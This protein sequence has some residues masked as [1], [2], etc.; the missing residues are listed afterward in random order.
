MGGRFGS[1][2]WDLRSTVV[3]GLA[4]LTIVSVLVPSGVSAE[5]K[6]RCAK[7]AHPGGDWSTFG[8]DAANSRYQ[9]KEKKLTADAVGLIAPQWTFSIAG[10]GADGNFQSSPVVADGCLYAG[11]NTGWLFGL[12][13]DTGE[14]VWKTHLEADDPY[15]FGL[16]GGVFS[17]AH[18]D[19]KI[20]GAVSALGSPY[21]VALDAAT[22]KIL[23]KTVVA[24]DKTAYTNASP[25]FVENMVFVGISGPE[26]GPEDERH[27]G[28]WALVDANSGR[29]ITREYTI[30]K[31]D[32]ARGQKGASLW[33]T[34]A[35]D[36]QSG[37]LF[38][39]TGQPANKDQEHSLSNAVIKIGADRGRS[40]FARVVD[41]YKGD[42]DDR[43]DVDFGASPT[44]F[45]DKKGR[46]IIGLSQKSGKFHA[47]FADTMEQ[48]WWF[49]LSDRSIL[50]NTST[51]ATDGKSIFV[52][53][54]TQT[55][56]P[57]GLNATTFGNK[58]PNPGYLYALNPNSG[59]VR[60]RTPIASG[61]E[62]HLIAAGGDVVWVVTTHGVLLGLDASSGV[63]VAARS[64]AA[65]VADPCTNLS[66][67]PIV[68]RNKVYA[69]CDIGAVGLGWIAAYGL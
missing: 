13:A 40:N 30:S 3:L 33:G 15:G 6:A 61:V 62:Y 19:G 14:L 16:S 4:F 8:Q 36:T 52:A 32:D 2:S 45:T 22:G 54:N 44:L 39:G 34:A 18:R 9:S 57:V 46:K 43:E 35:Y 24:K 53:G 12:N 21:L 66:S 23:W 55:A 31:E 50:G 7:A 27:P 37:F 68:A 20:Y 10:A 1:I 64:V 67:G 59:A 28:G 5:P 11:T 25:V 48:A 60:W 65:D 38:D 58:E 49:R 69:V 17:L 26:D 29:L 47:M 56:V 51:A 41:S 63:P 42:M